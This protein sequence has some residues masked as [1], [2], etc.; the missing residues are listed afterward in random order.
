[1]PRRKHKYKFVGATIPLDEAAKLERAARSA[2]RSTANL[3][4]LILHNWLVEN[5]DEFKRVS[6]GAHLRS[7]EIEPYPPRMGDTTLD[8][9]TKVGRAIRKKLDALQK[10]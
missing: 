5:S 10:R 3:I 8:T 2:K 6:K 4:E 1:M 7:I 9:S